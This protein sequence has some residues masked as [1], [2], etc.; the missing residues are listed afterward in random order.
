MFFER[1]KTATLQYASPPGVP[2]CFSAI[3]ARFDAI[4]RARR[5]WMSDRYG[6]LVSGSERLA[7]SAASGFAK[8]R[9]TRSRALYEM[10]NWHL[11]S[12][13]LSIG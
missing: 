4:A 5:T 9:V 11:E 2:Y 3:W 13:A 1:G 10:G 7:P 8:L 12:A 6:C